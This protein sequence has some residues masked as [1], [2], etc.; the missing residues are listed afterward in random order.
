M[1]VLML[2]KACYVAAYRRKLEE[3]ANLPGMDLT[4]V[5]P[6]Y[7]R[8]GRGKAMLEPGNDRG[9]R[10]I[11]DNPLFN[12][13]HHL[14]FYPRLRHILAQ[15]KPQL[16]HI[17]EEPY[18][19]VTFH[20]LRAAQKAGARVVFFTWQ[21][22]PHSYPPPFSLMEA[23]V[24]RRVQGAIAGNQEAAAILRRKGFSGPLFV[25]PQFGIDP[26]TFSPA[27]PPP[28]APFRIGYVGRLV[29]EK[30]LLV[31]LRAVAGLQGDWRLELVGDGPLRPKI[32]ALARE[33]GVG[34]RLK[35]WGSLPSAQVPSFLRTLHVL[36]L[37]SLTT[38][39]WKEQFGRALVEAMAC[40]VAAVG[41][42]S[43]EI[44]HVIGDAGLVC[45]EGDAEDLRRQLRRTM[46][47]PA[48]RLELAERGRQRAALY[49]Q[50]RVAQET[51]QAYQQIL[52]RNGA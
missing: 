8:Q 37:P 19:L 29:E 49:T 22:L 11:V 21:N 15:L 3:L 41:S 26:A 24:L 10:I 2:S 52:G 4:L 13:H 48:L 47:E 25:I 14:H 31:L 40:Q 20:A 16:I 17:D 9:Y 6:P 51:W 42:D 45:R 7:W 35:L 33:L 50:K 39:R 43:G 27:S 44:P 12:G 30:G 36:V 28:E 5:V 1:K 23:Y 18:N 46:E 32:Q 34:E 38:K